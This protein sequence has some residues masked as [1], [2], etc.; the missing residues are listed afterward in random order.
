MSDSCVKH[1]MSAFSVNQPKQKEV[2]KRC[3]SEVEEGRMKRHN[4]NVRLW[5]LVRMLWS[6]VLHETFLN[7]RIKLRVSFS[8]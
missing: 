3:L 5:R 2:K 4:V 8:L 7:W 6:G 1:F